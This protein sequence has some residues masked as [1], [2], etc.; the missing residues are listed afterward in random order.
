MFTSPTLCKTTTKTTKQANKVKNKAVN[1]IFWRKI[2]YL[3]R[4][5]LHP[6]D[7][8][9]IKVLKFLL[10][11]L[12]KTFSQERSSNA[13]KNETTLTARPLKSRI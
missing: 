7:Y 10:S 11:P 13:I 1:Q 2:K 6:K 3:A 12:S 8:Q 5:I 4:L 9:L